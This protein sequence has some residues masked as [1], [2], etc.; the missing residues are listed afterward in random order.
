MDIDGVG[1]VLVEQMV[2]SG[3]VKDVADI[4]FLTK[5]DFLKL[6]RTGEKTASNL[7]R[8]IEA[9]K[10][11]GLS[12]LLHGLGACLVGE[13]A[14]EVLAKRFQTMDALV[15]ATAD[16]LA[17][18]AAIGPKIAE[19][20][21]NLFRDEYTK[22]VLAKLAMAGV[23]MECEKEEVK[24]EMNNSLQGKA[25]VVTGTLE[26]F[27]RNEIEDT[28]KSH[29]GIASGSVSRKTSFVL[30]GESPGSKLAKARDLGIPI[31]TED[32]FLEMIG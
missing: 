11:K 24:E 3:L 21:F 26:H 12:R 10:T 14:S 32:E 29:G 9:S 4:Y 22:A 17:T 27:T 8:A 5:A 31:L 19:S 23:K 20:A 13:R 6:D 7:I 2:D 1:V 25:I 15:A 18:Q 30:V 28:I 16:D